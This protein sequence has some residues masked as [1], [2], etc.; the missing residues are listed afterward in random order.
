MEGSCPGGGQCNGTGGAAGCNG[1]PAYNN[2]L[3]KKV[4]VSSQGTRKISQTDAQLR[5]SDTGANDTLSD[6]DDQEDS[7]APQTAEM[8]CKNCGT[9]VTPLW[10]RDEQG[11]TICNA[12]GEL[13]GCITLL[14]LTI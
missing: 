2:R 10:R 8:S 9:T 7:G 14:K 1:C 12:C 4:Q 3:S 5:L 13:A 6:T 11:H